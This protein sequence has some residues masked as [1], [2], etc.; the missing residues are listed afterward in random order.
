MSTYDRYLY[1]FKKFELLIIGTV[2]LSVLIMRN[3]NSCFQKF[4]SISNTKAD[5]T[6]KNNSITFFKKTTMSS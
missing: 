2:H 1:V 3:K 4:I 6:L 5:H